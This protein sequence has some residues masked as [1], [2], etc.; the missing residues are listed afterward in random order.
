MQSTW[1]I[2]I[3]CPRYIVL[4][5]RDELYVNYHRF[6]ATASWNMAHVD[7]F[8]IDDVPQLFGFVVLVSDSY[9]TDLG[10]RW[11]IG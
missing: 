9:T 6:E 11:I 3:N 2:S 4:L 1:E 5:W 10:R 7:S 8:P